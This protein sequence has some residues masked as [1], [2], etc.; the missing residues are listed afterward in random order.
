MPLWGYALIVLAGLALIPLV[1]LAGRRAG[2]KMR[3]NLALASILL[4]LGQ[5]VD[6]P[7][8]HL[9]EAKHEDE[10]GPEAAGDPPLPG[11]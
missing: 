2:K 10:E 11:A 7:L 9:I 8:K 6:P 5:P 1:A 3:G 4:G